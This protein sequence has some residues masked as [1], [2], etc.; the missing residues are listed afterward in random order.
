MKL[1][2]EQWRQYIKEGSKV[3]LHTD[4]SYYGAEVDDSVIEGKPVV[5]LDI[6]YLSGFEPDE[7]MEDPES[8]AAV[9]KI[10]NLVIA[11]EENQLP[12][13]LVRKHGTGYQVIDG[14]HRFH[15]FKKAG[16][17]KIKAIIIPDEEI[18]EIPYK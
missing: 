5:S 9:E 11:G 7:K 17:E 15:G 4:P 6:K 10:S 12:P 1:L 2:M 16:A 8:F 14:H 3:K 13:I 18:E